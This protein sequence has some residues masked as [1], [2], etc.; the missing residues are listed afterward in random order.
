MQN[1]NYSTGVQKQ[2]NPNFGMALYADIEEI[3]KQLGKKTAKDVERA[4]DGM[5][6]FA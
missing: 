3:G 1:V 4:I 2:N 6:E 5:Q